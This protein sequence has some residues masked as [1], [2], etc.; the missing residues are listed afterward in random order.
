[1]DMNKFNRDFGLRWNCAK[2]MERGDFGKFHNRVK[3]LVTPI[4]VNNITSN[5]DREYLLYIGSES[6]TRMTKWQ[7]DNP[8]EEEPNGW[9]SQIIT[10][11][12][13]AKN[14]HELVLILQW[15]FCT[16]EDIGQI[17]GDMIIDIASKLKIAID[18]SPYIGIEVA[19][20]GRTVTLYPAG[21]KIL[22][23][24]V[25]NQDLIW[26]EGYPEPAKFFQKALD[27]YLKKDTTKYRELLDNLRNALEQLAREILGKETSLENLNNDKY[28]LKWLKQKGVNQEVIGMYH[29]LLE[30]FT[31]YQ[32]E[33]AKHG[34][35]WS[36]NEVE[37]MIYLTGIFMRMLLQLNQNSSNEQVCV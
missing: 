35:S 33:H 27:T 16:F 26:L 37:F 7:D 34:D 18:Y 12:S 10:D 3:V 9:N 21:A 11:I 8:F 4:I 15:T 2:N 24:N 13:Y 14:L 31:D 20:S 1:M 25:I 23:E 22:D 29:K 30:H 6:T 32:N 19:I 36:P 17:T 28:L 5:I